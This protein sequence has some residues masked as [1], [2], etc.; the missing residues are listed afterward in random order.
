MALS[1]DFRV[2]GFSILG[3]NIS[4]F[5]LQLLKNKSGNSISSNIEVGICI[6]TDIGGGRV[7]DN[8]DMNKYVASL[9]ALGRVSLL[10]D[11]GGVVAFLCTDDAKWVNA[12]RIEVSGGTLI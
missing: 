10:D 9:T 6:E 8:Q 2:E 4:G 12:Q 7:R 3:N 11:V 5:I 1:L